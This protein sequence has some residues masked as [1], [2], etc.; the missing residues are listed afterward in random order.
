MHINYGIFSKVYFNSVALLSNIMRYRYQTE[1]TEEAKDQ[2]P[3]GLLM[4]STIHWNN[5]PSN[6]S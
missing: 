3:P 5:V 2:F 4:T 6:F 1:T